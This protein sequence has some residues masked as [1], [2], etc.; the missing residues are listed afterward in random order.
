MV[1]EAARHKAV[2]IAGS[3]GTEVIVVDDDAEEK[4][5]IPPKNAVVEGGST[6]ERSEE[7]ETAVT[8]DPDKPTEMTMSGQ[9]TA[10]TREEEAVHTIVLPAAV[11]TLATPLSN[12]P[13]TAAR[14]RYRRAED[15]VAAARGYW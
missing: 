8:V 5:A 11:E 3:A 13:T 9:V 4:R 15:E 10:R 1:D 6:D 7:R 12:G 2:M 14:R